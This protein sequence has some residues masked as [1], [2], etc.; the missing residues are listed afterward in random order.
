MIAERVNV[1]MGLSGNIKFQINDFPV[2]PKSENI[3]GK[4]NPGNTFCK[5]RKEIG[6]KCYHEWETYF[7]V[8]CGGKSFP[9]FGCLLS[10]PDFLRQYRKL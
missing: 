10:F 9:I 7:Y 2:S 6:K 1:F 8:F 5:T 3:M 4:G